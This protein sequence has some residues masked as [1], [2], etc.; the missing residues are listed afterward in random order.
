MQGLGEKISELRKR[1]N[2]TQQELADK[3]HVSNKVISNW[4][5]GISEPDIDSIKELSSIFNVSVGQ[6]L[7][8]TEENKED[9][10]TKFYKF[11]KKNY[12]TIV[13][14][15]L[16][17]AGI[18][19]AMAGYGFL[20]GLDLVISVL[21]DYL[22]GIFLAFSL[23]IGLIQVFVTL[24]CPG[25]IFIAIL[26]YILTILTFTLALVGYVFIG[27]L[28]GRAQDFFIITGIAYTFLFVASL[29]NLLLDRKVINKDAPFKL[30]KLLR[31][32]VLIFLGVE[33][34]LVAGEIATCSVY[35][36]DKRTPEYISLD[37]TQYNFD[38]VGEIIEIEV[39]YPQ[40]TR[41]D[42]Y[43]L[44]SS[45]PSVVKVI[46]NNS[47]QSV[48][49]GQ[50]EITIKTEKGASDYA[51]VFV[52]FPIIEAHEGDEN[53]TGEMVSANASEEKTFVID[54]PGYNSIEE[55]ENRFNLVYDSDKIDITNKEFTGEKLY[56]SVRFKSIVGMTEYSVEISFQD[57]S[58][59][60]ILQVL[61][62]DVQDISS[63]EIQDVVVKAGELF[64][65]DMLYLPENHPA[66]IEYF[67]GDNS[68][69]SEV[70]GRYLALKEGNTTITAVSQNG[71]IE[72]A[73]L[74]IQG[75]VSFT[76]IFN[77]ESLIFHPYSGADTRIV[78]FEFDSE[79]AYI[80]EIEINVESDVENIVSFT[81]NTSNYTLQVNKTIG[82]AKISFS[83]PWFTSEEF[84]I[85]SEHSLS[86]YVNECHFKLD[87]FYPAIRYN[88]YDGNRYSDDVLIEIDNAERACFIEDGE[89]CQSIQKS[90]PLFMENIVVWTKNEGEV[91]ITVTSL[92]SGEQVKASFIIKG[93]DGFDYRQTTPSITLEEGQSIDIDFAI[94]IFNP[95][96]YDTWAFRVNLYDEI[97]LNSSETQL[98]QY[99]KLEYP[100]TSAD[101]IYGLVRV[102]AGEIQGES[103]EVTLIISTP[104]G[105]T[106]EFLINIIQTSQ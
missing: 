11:F 30:G 20:I 101:D 50:A 87:A 24:V 2:L 67:F 81:K 93:I 12:M 26:K 55:F 6:L 27:F 83:S 65:L 92:E 91:T 19:C 72:T 52:P 70:D 77:N 95:N 59:Q 61:A 98:L 84:E 89:H 36:Y 51:Y 90:L 85:V 3:L 62:I 1:Q 104:E 73:S 16:V 42:K 63:I 33:I 8:A 102:T 28:A 7:D 76:P 53:I 22:I 4:E 56:L 44:V 103:E 40:Y 60:E 39:E 49:Y 31:V 74:N 23:G 43:T 54:I 45:N 80:P 79:N 10:N 13:Q 32:L 46:D 57:V 38:S 18:I 29:L 75:V 68:L 58:S 97:L 99:E 5:R 100:T 71:I 41:K 82:S 94:K 96:F 34:L 21:P 64:D 9:L 105:R 25:N 15:I 37:R 35:F 47:I 86:I 66:G 69:I 88:Y 106:L 17:W 78:R 14:L 48:G